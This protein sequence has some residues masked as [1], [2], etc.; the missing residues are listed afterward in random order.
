LAS[1]LLGYSH[2]D[3]SESSAANKEEGGGYRTVVTQE[4]EREKKPYP[5]AS[6]LIP[7]D[8]GAFLERGA[9]AMNL[10]RRTIEFILPL[11]RQEKKKVVLE[12]ELSS[13][14]DNSIN[15]QVT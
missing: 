10:A 9:E 14:T 1:L 6:Q 12:E 4:A 15:I 13:L 7:A 2:F 8:M 3:I 11:W 5:R